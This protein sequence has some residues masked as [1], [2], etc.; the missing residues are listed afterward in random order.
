MV[1]FCTKSKD[2]NYN[3]VIS[4]A[5]PHN[6]AL[7]GALL[8]G[9][10]RRTE[11]NWLLKSLQEGIKSV[12]QLSENKQAVEVIKTI[13]LCGEYPTQSLYLINN[14]SHEYLRKTL[15]E[16]Q[17]ERYISKLGHGEYKRLRLLKKGINSLKGIL[18]QAAEQYN[19]ITDNQHY[20][21]SDSNVSRTLRISETRQL[22]LRADAHTA[23]VNKPKL[24]NIRKETNYRPPQSKRR[25]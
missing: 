6:C 19:S 5:K 25:S 20:S 10:I 24:P 22:M 2:L 23:T 14:N 3:H 11:E 4:T 12:I 13:A 16:L 1:V 7:L 9:Q 8:A 15:R 21:G 18:P 17:T